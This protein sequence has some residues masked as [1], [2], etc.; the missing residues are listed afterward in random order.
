MNIIHYSDH[1]YTYSKTYNYVK[2]KI[3]TPGTKTH[4]KHKPVNCDTI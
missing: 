3:L 4:N 2:G 1:F